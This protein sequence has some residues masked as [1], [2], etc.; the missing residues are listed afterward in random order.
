LKAGSNLYVGMLSGT[1]RDGVDGV[2]VRFDQD[3]PELLATQCVRYPDGLAEV[4]RRMIERGRRP[5]KEALALVDRELAEFFALAGWS[6]LDQAGIEATSLA[7]IGSHGQT[8]WHAP[9]GAQP[10]TIQL[11]DPQRIADL[12]G[13]V[14][15]GNFRQ[16]D[17]RAGGQGA[18]LAPLLH[19]TLL[20]PEQGIR[21]VLNI[22]GIANV[23][24]VD[25]NGTVRGYDTGPGNCLLD[26]WVQK[27]QHQDFD[28]GGRWASTGKIDIHLLNVLLDDPYFSLGPPK[29]TGVEYFN[30]Y[31]L[32]SRLSQHAQTTPEDVQATLSEFTAQSVA[33][34][35]QASAAHELL[36]CGGGAHNDDLMARLARLLPGIAVNTT[37]IS[38]L[39]PDWM[40]GILFAWLARER[41]ARRHQHTRPITGARQDVLLGDVFHPQSAR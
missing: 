6:L 29:S 1:S 41:L 10:E 18:P 8:V 12:L 4:L 9:G 34:E 28:A 25:A 32:Q 14:T 27:R 16:A 30:I 17:L 31:W 13:T 23:S 33:N 11:G 37:A 5:H 38:G 2:L 21:A 3:R 15:V 22:G 26:A 36:V 7:A 40:E 19:R 24:L 20:Q 35:I 39:D